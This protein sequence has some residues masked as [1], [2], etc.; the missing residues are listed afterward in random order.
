[1]VA[2]MTEVMFKQAMKDKLTEDKYK[3]HRKYAMQ[4]LLNKQFSLIHNFIFPSAS[5]LEVGSGVGDFLLY[6]RC[7][8]NNNIIGIDISEKSVEITNKRLQDY[9]FSPAASI[10]D[11]YHISDL[12]DKNS[13]FD[14]VVMRGV[15][16]HL[17]NPQLAVNN[18]FKILKK[19]GK[20][21]ILEGN[22]SSGYRN[23]VLK[24]A[25]ILG[26]K[27]EASKFS[28]I[29]PQVTK[30]LL[31]KAGFYNFTIQFLPGVFSPFVYMGLGN[32]FFWKMAD[33]LEEK[34]IYRISPRF[35]SWWFLL[36]AS[37]PDN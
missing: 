25:D 3:I 22:I 33:I 29:H 5:I 37:K 32:K 9:G 21:V 27:H 15:I 13:L 18:I 11:V 36:V 17:E 14:A 26:I 1:M 31:T 7:K 4:N 2:V 35:F 24:L 20:I 8:N 30:R 19:G 16:H 23:S 28:H 12:R 6:C 34:F 10:G